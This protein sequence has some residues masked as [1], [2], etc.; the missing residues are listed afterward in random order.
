MPDF[1]WPPRSSHNGGDGISHGHYI[2]VDEPDVAVDAVRRVVAQ[3][4]DD[5]EVRPTGGPVALPLR[6]RGT[7]HAPAAS[8]TA[9]RP[10][11]YAVEPAGTKSSAHSA[12]RLPCQVGPSLTNAHSGL[13]RTSRSAAQTSWKTGMPASAHS[14]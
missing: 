6:C 5:L 8:T 11:G 3:V 1:R 12:T 14:K 7:D 2:Y 13:R 9:R 10:G 4:E